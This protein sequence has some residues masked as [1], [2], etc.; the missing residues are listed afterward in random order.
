MADQVGQYIIEVP[1]S[2]SEDNGFFSSAQIAGIGYGRY[3]IRQDYRRLSGLIQLPI[4]GPLGTPARIVR[5]N[6]GSAVKV[7]TWVVECLRL[8]GEKPTLPHWDTGDSNEALIYSSIAVDQ[9]AI[10]PDGQTFFWRVRGEYHLAAWS[11]RQGSFSGGSSPAI[12]LPPESFG[13][14]EGDFSR[15]FL[16]SDTSQGS[17]FKSQF[18][19]MTFDSKLE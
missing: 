13:L 2:V 6:S 14:T 18:A 17:N 4:A 5:L 9:P 12:T 7:V 1:P 16:R 10:Q 11:A 3:N 15:D 8:V 19:G